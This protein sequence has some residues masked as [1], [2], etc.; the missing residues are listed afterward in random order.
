M[1]HWVLINFIIVWI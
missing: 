1:I